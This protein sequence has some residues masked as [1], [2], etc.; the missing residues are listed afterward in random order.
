LAHRGY[1]QTVDHPEI[2]ESRF[3]SPPFL[4]DGER[5]E[6]RRPPLLGEHSEDVLTGLLGYSPERV[7]ALRAEGVLE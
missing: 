2:G 5:I 3:T 4:L 6:L 7:K 1:W